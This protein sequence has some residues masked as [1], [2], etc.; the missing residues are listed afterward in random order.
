[1]SRASRPRT[2][3]TAA[4]RRY[5]RTL[6]QLLLSIE[7]HSNDELPRVII[8]DLG[9][10]S[11]DRDRLTRRFPWCGLVPFSFD[12]YPAHV[13]QLDTCAWKPIA[14]DEALRH[15]GGLVLWLDSATIVRAGLDPVFDRIARDGLLTL[16]GQSPIAR[17]CHD[18]TRQFIGASRTQA[19]ARCRSAGILG[20]DSSRADVRALAA[21]WRRLALIPEC[22]DPPGATRA[23]HRYDQAILS[24]LVVTH[25]ELAGTSDEEDEVDI[26][27]ARPVPWASTRNKVA[28]WVPLACDPIVRAYYAAYKAADRALIRARA[29]GV[30]DAAFAIEDL[31]SHALAAAFRRRATARARGFLRGKSDLRGRRCHCAPADVHL[32]HSE[33]LREA[34]DVVIDYASNVENPERPQV[35]LPLVRDIASQIAAGDIVHVKTDHL[36]AFVRDILPRASGPL[37][38]VT[39]DSDISPVRRF[40]HLLDDARILH[41][42]AQNADVAYEHPRLTRV[43]IGLD[44]PIYTKLEKRLGFALAAMLGKIP[45]DPSFRRNAMGDQ[46]RLHQVKRQMTRTVVEKPARVLCTFHVNHRLLPDA[47]SIPDRAEAYAAL[48]D[49]PDCHVIQKRLPQEE[50][51]RAHDDFAFEVSPRGKGLDCFR[52]WECL[53]LGT[54]PIVKTSP[55]DALYRQEQ[56]PVVI[57]ESY[58]EITSANLRHWKTHLEGCFTPDLIGRLSNDYW[59]ERIRSASVRG[60]AGRLSNDVAQGGVDAG[61]R[62]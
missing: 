18:A 62:V 25:R 8:V 16:A 29:H 55:L 44:N 24:L 4:D 7:R 12:A 35:P 17:W 1:V 52:T 11:R 6:G 9:L 56:L 37:V 20:F 41:W 40:E 33:G 59:V 26:S 60:W 50:F 48:R 2:I 27:S 36:D 38:L 32:V 30:R 53:F 31:A 58:D 54:I 3:V 23:N 5:A 42:F 43:P 15:D 22:I 34:C 13:R 45:F 57:V 28:T 14:I 46:A 19:A 47:D 61:A 49:H 39:G 51:W 21:E 10:A